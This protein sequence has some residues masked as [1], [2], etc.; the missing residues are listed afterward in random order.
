M[1]LTIILNYS[2]PNDTVSLVLRT[3][4]IGNSMLVKD[5]VTK[6]KDLKP[7]PPRGRMIVG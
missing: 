4:E 2:R 3:H 5:D 6:E 1:P 7:W